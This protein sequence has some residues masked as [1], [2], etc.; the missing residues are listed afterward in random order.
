[1]TRSIA[2]AAL[3]LSLV[4]GGWTGWRLTRGTAAEV[5]AALAEQVDA[6]TAQREA[7]QRKAAY[8]DS[9]AYYETRIAEA[10]EAH[11]VEAPT[12][13]RLR[14]AN[15]LYHPVSLSAP[16]VL[17]AGSARSFGPLRLRVVTREL[18]LEQGGIRTKNIHTLL[19]LENTGELPLAYRLGARKASAG[20]CSVRALTRFDAVVIDPGAKLEISICGGEHA[21]EITELRMLELTELGALWVRQIPALALGV[22][23]ETAKV[24]DPGAKIEQCTELPITD[25]QRWLATQQ[26]AWEDIVDFYSRHDCNSYRWWKGYERA[27]EGVESLPVL[28]PDA[29]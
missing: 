9:E 13:D 5:E 8:E 14:Q 25:Y 17:E 29:Q 1:M 2:V 23:R 21:V 24:H 11:G 28:P 19:V 26:A 10:V 16:K 18:T 3:G 4:V 20:K 7:L 27:V 15:T 12:L 6:E 22:S